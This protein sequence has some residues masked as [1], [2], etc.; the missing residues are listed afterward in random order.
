MIRKCV[1]EEVRREV[2][3]VG[4]EV[5]DGEGFWDS[6]RMVLKYRRTVEL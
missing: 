2:K 1:E 3:D 5:S 6:E 4:D